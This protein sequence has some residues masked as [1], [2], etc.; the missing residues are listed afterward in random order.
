MLC[1]YALEN[2]HEILFER[3]VDLNLGLCWVIKN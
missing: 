2:I 3:H 1:F